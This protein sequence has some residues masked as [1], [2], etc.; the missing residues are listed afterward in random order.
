[1][2]YKNYPY[3]RNRSRNKQDSNIDKYRSA[4]NLPIK[5]TVT[6]KKKGSRLQLSEQ[7][8]RI[9]ALSIKGLLN[10]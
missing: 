7:A 9:I 1:M 6:G 10:S 4:L 3:S 5:T 2:N 8:A